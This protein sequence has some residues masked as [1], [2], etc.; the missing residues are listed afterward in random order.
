MAVVKERIEIEAPIERV[1]ETIMDPN[2]FADWVTIHRSVS[3][4]SAD[5]QAKGARMDQLMHMRGMNFRVHWLLS[6][7]EPPRLAVWDG[8]GPA[9]SRAGIRYELS[10]GVDGRPTVFDYTNDFAVPGG[11]LGATASRFVVGAASEREAQRSLAR[12]KSLVERG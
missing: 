1:W 9:H 12:L 8:S 7:V 4:V 11:F 2:R 10:G 3:N 5:P 6:Q